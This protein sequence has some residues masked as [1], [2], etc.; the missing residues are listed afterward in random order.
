M[1]L[2]FGIDGFSLR[3]T[4]ECEHLWVYPVPLFCPYPHRPSL[5]TIRI[6]EIER[7]EEQSVR[8]GWEHRNCERGASSLASLWHAC[9]YKLDS[10]QAGTAIWFCLLSVFSLST[11]DLVT[12]FRWSDNECTFENDPVL[13]MRN[14]TSWRTH[15]TCSQSWF[16]P[17]WS[18]LTFPLLLT[19]E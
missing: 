8:D 4:C 12:A 19:V 10:G 16:S 11:W 7:K 1:C 9:C 17:V 18:V 15:H 6:P 13:C 14:S 2:T 5:G 3:R